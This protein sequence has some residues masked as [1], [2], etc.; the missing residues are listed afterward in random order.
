MGVSTDH[1]LILRII[2]IGCST[3]MVIAG[4]CVAS[5]SVKAKSPWWQVIAGLIVSVIIIMVG[6]RLFSTGNFLGY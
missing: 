3:I 6:Y 1:A 5:A 2:S 4:A